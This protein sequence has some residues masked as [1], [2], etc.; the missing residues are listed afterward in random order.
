MKNADLKKGSTFNKNMKKNDFRTEIKNLTDDNLIVKYA[1]LA[2]FELKNAG[3]SFDW[4]RRQMN[5]YAKIQLD[6]RGIDENSK[7]FKKLF[8]ETWDRHDSAIYG[9]IF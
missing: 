5:Q 1:S 4:R 3:M 6:K 8:D 2:Y 7:H 9:K